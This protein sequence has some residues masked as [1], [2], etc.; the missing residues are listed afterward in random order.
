MIGIRK[1]SA[2]KFVTS[3]TGGAGVELFAAEGGCIYLQDP[4]GQNI[5]FKFGGAG[6]GLSAGLKVP[7]IGKITLPKVRGRS[8][9]G[10]AAPAAFP[11]AGIVIFWSRF[12]GRSCR[13]RTS[14]AFASSPRLAE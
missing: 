1:E 3:A 11:N 14:P 10:G 5:T 7:K 2:W 4:S 13:G 8:V 12:R 9:G 6:V